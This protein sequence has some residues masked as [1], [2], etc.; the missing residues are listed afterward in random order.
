MVNR[1][2]NLLANRGIHAQI[3]PLRVRGAGSG[4]GIFLTA[5]YE[6]VRAGFSSIGEKGKPSERVAE[7]VVDRFLA[8]DDREGAID[9]YLADQLMLPMAL[10]GGQSEMTVSEISQHLI[11]NAHIIRQFTDAQIT[12]QGEKDE[13]GYVMVQ[14]VNYVG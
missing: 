5:E 12:I 9:R 4:A 3:E 1:A 8:F 2:R 10:A 14:G 11:T 6:K 7:E 13:S